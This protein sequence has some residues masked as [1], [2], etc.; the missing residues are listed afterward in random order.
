MI[1]EEVLKRIKGMEGKDHLIAIIFLLPFH[2]A[3]TP[4]FTRL[5]QGDQEKG[6]L[7][8]VFVLQTHRFVEFDSVVVSQL[9]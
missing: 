1:F 5:Y 8:T 2:S 3:G 9:P 7:E 6:R 4:I